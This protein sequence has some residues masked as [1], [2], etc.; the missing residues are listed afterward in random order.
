[1]LAHTA[2]GDRVI[3]SRWSPRRMHIVVH[4][5]DLDG[6]GAYDGPEGYLGAGVPLEAELP[7]AC[8]EI[9]RR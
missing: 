3:R 4:G 2:E 5:H 1:M 6:S 8:G 9:T 7:M